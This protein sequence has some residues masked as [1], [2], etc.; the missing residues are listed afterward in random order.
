MTIEEN[1]ETWWTAFVITAAMCGVALAAFFVYARAAGAKTKRISPPTKR[2]GPPTKRERSSKDGLPDLEDLMKRSL[3]PLTLKKMKIQKIVPYTVETKIE[4]RKSLESRD[5][6]PNFRA[7]VRKH[8]AKLSRRAARVMQLNIGLYC[9][10]ACEHCHVDSTPKRGSEMMSRENADHCLRIIRNSPSVEI[11]DITGGAPELNREFKYIV[12]NVRKM[13][14]HIID[15]CN[16]TVL[17]EPRQKGLAEFLRDHEVHIIA[18]L[19]CY[20]ESNVD[21]QRGDQVFARSIRALQ[22]LNRL[23]YGKGDSKLQLD[24]VYNPTGVHLPP[25]ASKLQVDYKRVLKEKYG[26]EFDKLICITNMPINRFHDFLLKE[27][28][29]ETYMRLLYDEFN[30]STCDNLMCVDYV[31]VG[32]DGSVYDCDFNQQIELARKKLHVS[33]MQSVKDLLNVPIATAKHW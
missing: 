6:V 7:T 17:L 20:L 33:E 23:G 12:R 2:I 14:L 1:V 22:L 26:I 24:L 10:Q 32:Y 13:G 30:P 31:S 5:V 3:I 25:S 16:L 9:N 29:L 27:K 28:K 21:N 11:V 18:S 15:R 8:G 19:P 4:K